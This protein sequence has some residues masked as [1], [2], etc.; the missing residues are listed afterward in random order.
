[1]NLMTAAQNRSNNQ[2]CIKATNLSKNK[3]LK[4]NPMARTKD[5]D[6]QLVNKTRRKKLRARRTTKPSNPVNLKFL[7]LMSKTGHENLELM[8]PSRFKK[9]SLLNPIDQDH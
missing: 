5:K 7:Q 1:M 4:F 8:L 9:V 6:H 3:K 2:T